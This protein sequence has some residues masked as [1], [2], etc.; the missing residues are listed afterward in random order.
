MDD[1]QLGEFAYDYVEVRR[2]YLAWTPAQGDEIELKPIEGV[3]LSEAKMRMAK[4]SRSPLIQS[5]T[6]DADVIGRRSGDMRNRR[7]LQ[8][9]LEEPEKMGRAI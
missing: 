3:G 6:S 5:P 9:D 7:G 1:D 4:E 8:S 2:D